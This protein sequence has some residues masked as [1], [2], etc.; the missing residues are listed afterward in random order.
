[1]NL[2][3]QTLVMFAFVAISVCAIAQT[4]GNLSVSVKTVTNSG[5]YAPRHIMAIWV[6]DANGTFVKTLLFRSQNT[7]YRKYLTKFKAATS[8]TY[9]SVDASTGATYNSHST[10]T[11]SW[12]GKNVSEAL[13]A[14]GTYK[15]CVEFTESNGSGPYQEYTFTKSSEAQ[16]LTPTSVTNFQ[17][18]TISWT[19]TSSLTSVSQ[20]ATAMSVYPNPIKD[21]ATITLD[22]NVQKIYVTNAEGKIV[23]RLAKSNI[24]KDNKAIWNPAKNL[25]NGVYFVVTE[26]SQ[27]KKATQ[28]ILNR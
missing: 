6:E 1:M 5:Q 22:A 9:N 28:V 11:A 26:T 18:V 10:R 27:I 2:F 15:L 23:A 25:K 12:N 3:K 8:S 17:N 21:Y 19:P 4:A 24:L 16:S 13:V 7:Q 14:D 20:N